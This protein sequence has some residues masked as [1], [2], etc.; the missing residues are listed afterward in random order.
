M[1]SGSRREGPCGTKTLVN[2]TI[3]IEHRARGTKQNHC[4]L[5]QKEYR[6]LLEKCGR[7]KHRSSSYLNK[8]K[9]KIF[10]TSGTRYSHQRQGL[11]RVWSLRDFMQISSWENQ[12]RFLNSIP[13]KYYSNT[14][15]RGPSTGQRRQSNR[16]CA[17]GTKQNY[18]SS[19]HLVIFIVSS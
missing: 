17:G 1:A 19:R 14:R 16:G 4:Q 13:F 15:S 8:L 7:D 6:K 9:C 12:L 5:T 2:G 18:P 3:E 10:R 11:T